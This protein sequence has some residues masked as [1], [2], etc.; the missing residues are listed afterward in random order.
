MKA[1]ANAKRG[2]RSSVVMLAC[3]RRKGVWAGLEY[4]NSFAF[5]SGYQET[6]VVLS[7]NGKSSYTCGRTFNF[8]ISARKARLE[9]CHTLNENNSSPDLSRLDTKLRQKGF[10]DATQRTMPR[11]KLPQSIHGPAAS[12][13]FDAINGKKRYRFSTK[14]IKPVVSMPQVRQRCRSHAV[15]PQTLCAHA[16]LGTKSQETRDRLSIWTIS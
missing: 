7:T 9:P 2:L 14:G 4:L 5:H 1:R 8:R 10:G 11:I 15:R 16:R 13:H 12:Q 3:R 6:I